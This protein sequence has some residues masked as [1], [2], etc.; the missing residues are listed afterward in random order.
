MKCRNLKKPVFLSL[1]S[2][3]MLKDISGL[4]LSIKILSENIKNRN[5]IDLMLVLF[6]MK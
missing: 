5:I 1:E 4:L 6:S 2:S 3:D